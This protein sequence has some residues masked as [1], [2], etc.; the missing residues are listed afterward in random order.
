MIFR[1]KLRYLLVEASDDVR[2]GELRVADELKTQ[3]QS[4]LGE[5]PYFK[6]NPQ[7][8]SQ[9]NSRVFAICVNRGY[10]R[11]AIL[12]LSFIKKLDG[13]RI[14]FYTIKTSGSMRSIKNTCRKTYRDGSR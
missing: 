10:E 13:K 14:G 8:A 12:A 3:M 11:N 7:I 6:A 5:L 2:A 9:W 4:F 1:K